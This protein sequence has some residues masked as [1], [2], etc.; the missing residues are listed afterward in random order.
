MIASAM[1][2]E[3]LSSEQAHSRIWLFNSKGLIENTRHDLI[4]VQKLYAHALPPT[5]DLLTAINSIK[6][7]IIIGVST[8]GKSFNQAVI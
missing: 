4:Q 6:P 7:A 8:V 2:L 5:N 1:Q 3:G